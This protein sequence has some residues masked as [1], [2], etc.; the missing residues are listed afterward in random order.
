MLSRDLLRHMSSATRRSVVVMTAANSVA[1]VMVAG[2]YLVY[3]RLMTPAE[4]AIYAG[5]LAIA[6]L[7]TITLDGGLKTALVKHDEAVDPGIARALFLGSTAASVAISATLAAVVFVL[8]GIDVLSLGTAAFFS[9]YG[10]AY[11]LTYPTLFVPL[12]QLEREQRFGPIARAEMLTVSIEYA[13]PALLWLL[14]APGFWSFVLAAWLARMLRTGMVLVA[15]D[16][17]AWLTRQYAP[18]W[19]AS[20]ALLTEGLGLQAAVCF[21]MLRDSLHLLLV[22]P[23]FGKDWAGFYAWAL[24]LC[25]VASQVFVQTATRVALPA[26]RQ[27]GDMPSRWRA[28]L[29]QITWLTLFTA[30]PLL[31]LTD[32]SRALNQDLFHAKWTPALAMLP[33]LVARMLPGLA[34]TPLGALVLAERDAR[35]YLN[36]NAW[37]T[38]IE[39]VFAVVL[40]AWIGPMGLAWSYSFSAWAGV[41]SLLRQLPPPASFVALLPPLVLRPSLWAALVLALLYHAAVAKGSMPADLG[42]AFVFSAIGVLCS[43][44]IERRCWHAVLPNLR[45]RASRK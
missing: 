26:L 10:A 32:F 7:G 21:S 37:W 1:L 6:K 8:V 33:F 39:L 4:F 30:P 24:Q 16:S 11:F 5:A 35:A 20:K 23:W 25:A 29:T 9:L 40:L 43:I 15:A 41:L 12:A 14:V 17:R 2:S 18:R 27:A 3:S 44:A 13:L 36:A 28:T 45:H 42:S 19:R 34:T 31:F 22:A 38:A